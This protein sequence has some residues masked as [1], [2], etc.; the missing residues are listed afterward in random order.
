M[1]IFGLSCVPKARSYEPFEPRRLRLYRLMDPV[2]SLIWGLLWPVMVALAYLT[3]PRTA[4]FWALHT[5]IFQ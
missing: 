1:R 2:I 4:R 3:S 5:N